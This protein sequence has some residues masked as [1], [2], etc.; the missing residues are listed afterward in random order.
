MS[1]G[2][3]NWYELHWSREIK[4]EQL[5]HALRVLAASSAVPVM[6]ESVG[7]CGGVVH[8]LALPT[9]SRADLARTVAIHV[10]DASALSVSKADRHLTVDRAVEL[11][12]STAS[13]SLSLDEAEAVCRALLTALST[14]RAAESVSLQWQLRSGAGGGAGRQPIGARRVQVVAYRAARERYLG[15]APVTRCRGARVAACEAVASRLAD[16]REDRCA[17]R[18]CAAAATSDPSGR[19]GAPISRG[20]GRSFRIAACPTLRHGQRPAT[21]AGADATERRRTRGGVRLAC[22]RNQLIADR[23]ADE[24]TGRA[25]QAR[26][27]ERAAYSGTRRFR[28]ANGR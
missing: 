8:R 14:V 18:G 9:V 5:T 17:R 7:V 16:Y 4:L 26:H 2:Q 21:L 24:P 27:L 25:E 20:A 23:E 12:L 13:R 3:L 19:L 1:R 22:R 11:R 10:A 28:V 15:P 6:I